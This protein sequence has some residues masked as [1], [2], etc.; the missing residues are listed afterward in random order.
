[1]PPYFHLPRLKTSI[2]EYQVSWD[3]YNESFFHVIQILQS[4]LQ[5]LREEERLSA[6]SVT[7]STIEDENVDEN[8]I[9]I[10]SNLSTPVQ[11]PASAKPPLTSASDGTETS[12]SE[13]DSTTT[14]TF[15]D[16]G[17]LNLVPDR[18]DFITSG[19]DNHYGI[20]LALPSL[21]AVLTI[22]F[23]TPDPILSSHFVFEAFASAISMPSPEKTV[24]HAASTTPPPHFV[25]VYDPGEALGANFQ[26]VVLCFLYSRQSQ[27]LHPRLELSSLTPHVVTTSQEAVS[28]SHPT[29]RPWVYTSRPKER[30]LAIGMETFGESLARPPPLGP[31]SGWSWVPQSNGTHNTRV[32]SPP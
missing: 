16:Q 9:S 7:G 22:F 29:E 18:S 32:S 1:M 14:E 3:R 11:P 31:A 24:V 26:S 20:V 25:S 4:E 6:M 21:V 27:Q 15:K 30:F 12:Y 19:F 5:Y 28:G 2:T 17:M 13:G 10:N 23:P 8:T